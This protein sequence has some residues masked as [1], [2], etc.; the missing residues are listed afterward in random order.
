VAID[1]VS[2][3]RPKF[4]QRWKFIYHRRLALEREMSEK[5]I[6][7]KSV[8]ELIKAAGLNK[9]VCNLGECYERLVKKFLVNVS[10]DSDNPLNREY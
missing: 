3:H 4:A 2:F 5:A 10:E 8:M 7:I 6:K 9:T 1:K